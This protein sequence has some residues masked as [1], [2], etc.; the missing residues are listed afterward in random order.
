MDQRI[1][2]LLGLI[3]SDKTVT[4]GLDQSQKTG[5]HLNISGACAE[6]K[7]FLISALASYKSKRPVVI[8]S[9]AARA[10]MMSR[11]LS[12]FTD[13]SVAVLLPAEL[14]LLTAE[15]SSRELELTR[16]A[17]LSELVKESGKSP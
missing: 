12:A 16:C 11:A 1:T 4:D 10:R 13:G 6:Q 9:D 3:K 17:A 14:S 15:A 5:R 7:A 2:E 8:V